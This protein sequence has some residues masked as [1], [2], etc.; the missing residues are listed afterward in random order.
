VQC[1][2]GRLVGGVVVFATTRYTD[3]KH[4]TYDDHEI[5]YFGVYCPQTDDV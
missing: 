5:D 4:R 1:R 2:T 3:R